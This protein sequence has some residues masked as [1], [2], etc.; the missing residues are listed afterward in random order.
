MF[1]GNRVGAGHTRSTI[2]PFPLPDSQFR[3]Q[4]NSV[5][6]VVSPLL[7]GLG[8]MNGFVLSEKSCGQ[9]QATS[10]TPIKPVVGITT[11]AL[12]T[13]NLTAIAYGRWSLVPD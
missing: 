11:P 13:C 12:C 4:V 10:Q 6:L 5:H 7:R 8:S 9:E 3:E 1:I 2:N